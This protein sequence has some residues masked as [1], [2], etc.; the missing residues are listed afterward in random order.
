MKKKSSMKG[1]TCP[2]VM[3]KVF[4]IPGVNEITKTL[5]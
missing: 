3:A 1:L 2:Y 5:V 4:L